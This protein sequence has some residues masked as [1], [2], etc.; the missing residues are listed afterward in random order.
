MFATVR[1]QIATLATTA[2]GDGGMGFPEARV[3]LWDDTPAALPSLCI[4]PSALSQVRQAKA[5][6]ASSISGPGS[7]GVL[8][9]TAYAEGPE[10]ADAA[11]VACL[12]TLIPERFT[13]TRAS[14][15]EDVIGG[16]EVFV[17][18]LD[19]GY[20]LSATIPTS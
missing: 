17:V 16:T 1:T 3:T 2:T 4:G 7:F 9:A 5:A 11:L 15:T 20:R 8:I 18:R 19:L 6:T 12:V 10:G 14:V 13:L